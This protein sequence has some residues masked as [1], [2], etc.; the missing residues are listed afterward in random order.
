[1]TGL[2]NPRHRLAAS[3]STKREGKKEKKNGRI[4]RTVLQCRRAQ[5]AKRG[6]RGFFF[7]GNQ[8]I[9]IITHIHDNIL[10]YCR[11]LL[12]VGSLMLLHYVMFHHVGLQ[13]CLEARN[14]V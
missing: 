13:M 1:M 5:Q 6:E 9:G 12:A 4:R 8:R 14:S 3:S 7:A 10:H 2:Q 11:S